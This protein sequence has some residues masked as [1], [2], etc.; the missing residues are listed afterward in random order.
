MIHIP[1]VDDI[2]RIYHSR[3]LVVWLWILTIGISIGAGV[4]FLNLRMII[5]GL[6]F[7]IFGAYPMFLIEKKH[8]K[9]K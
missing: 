3:P 5:F 1:L 8:K 7:W 9:A 4:H 6:I 2:T